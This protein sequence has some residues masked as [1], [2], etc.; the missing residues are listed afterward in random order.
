[1]EVSNKTQLSFIPYAFHLSA[2]TYRVRHSNRNQGKWESYIDYLHFVPVLPKICL[3][4][5]LLRAKRQH[6]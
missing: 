4:F 3:D 2:C 1:M 5:K 6:S